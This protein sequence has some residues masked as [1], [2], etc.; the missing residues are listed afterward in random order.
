[1]MIRIVV[2]T[3]VALSCSYA[4]CDDT[5]EIRSV[6]EANFRA[7]NEKDVGALMDT[8]SV[9]MH[10]REGFR[11]E[12]QILF[13]EKDVHYS[14]EDF[15][16]VLIRGNYAEARV[17]QVTYTEGRDSDSESRRRFRNG[18]TLLPSEECVEYMA[19]FRREGGSWKCLATISDPIPH[20]RVRIRN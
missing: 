8:C 5:D 1:M 12:S 16:I 4:F 7:C 11:R 6:L 9:M 14:L 15:E 20:S 2:S 13:R 3:L 10:D 19:S 18:T 17:V